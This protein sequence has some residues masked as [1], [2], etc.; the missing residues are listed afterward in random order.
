MFKRHANRVASLRR[1]LKITA[2]ANVTRTRAEAR[3]EPTSKE[4]R[5]AFEKET[6]MSK[7]L[8]IY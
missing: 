5:A 3:M 7:K 4:K 6:V 2:D 8:R 1:Q